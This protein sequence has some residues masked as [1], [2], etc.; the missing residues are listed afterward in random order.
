M[1]AF[2]KNA[3]KIASTIEKGLHVTDRPRL[4]NYLVWYLERSKT[5]S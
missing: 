1:L 3:E 5:L 4:P 2:P